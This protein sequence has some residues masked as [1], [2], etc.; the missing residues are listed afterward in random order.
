MTV[1]RLPSVNCIVRKLLN[2]PDIGSTTDNRKWK[3]AREVT[4]QIQGF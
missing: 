2:Q 1:V 3:E 4:S